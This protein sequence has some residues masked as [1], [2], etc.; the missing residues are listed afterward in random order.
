MHQAVLLSIVLSHKQTGP[1]V[2]SGGKQRPISLSELVLLLQHDNL[3]HEPSIERYTS[4]VSHIATY[5]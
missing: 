2:S 5:K 3:G 1:D 4:R